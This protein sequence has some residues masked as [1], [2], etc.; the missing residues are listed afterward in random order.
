MKRHL[1]YFFFLSVLTSETYTQSF[2][3]TNA[4]PEAE[5]FSSEKLYAMRDTLAGY[6]TSS[7]LVIRNDKVVLEWY[8]SGWNATRKYYTASLAK[9]LV[10]GMSLSLALNDGLMHIDDPVCKYNPDWKIIYTP[11]S[12]THWQIDDE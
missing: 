2:D 11:G 3:W 10:G 9:A 1:L 5:G 6:N 12:G 4:Y 7:I 8:A